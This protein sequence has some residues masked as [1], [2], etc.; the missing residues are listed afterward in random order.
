MHFTL[1]GEE[2]I[3]VIGETTNNEEA[4]AFIEANSPQ[5]AILNANKAKLTGIEITR[6]LKQNVPSV[7]IILVM[8]VENEELHFSALTSGASA[9]VSKDID[10]DQLLDIIREASQGKKPISA[11]LLKPGLALRALDE[12]EA[13][14]VISQRVDNLLARL[15][16]R[17][18]E[19][20]SHIGVGKSIQELASTAEI[21]EETIRRHLDLIVSKLVANDRGRRLIESTQH[22]LIAPGTALE[23]PKIEYITKDEFAEFKE[24]LRKSLESLFG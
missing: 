13:C 11:E 19:I 4:L 7:A 22:G 23:Q 8:D 3:D 16:P 5:V 14:S 1:S 15:N 24:N 2:D 6:R 18:A 9:C 20:L 17:E 10:P 21:S 12:F